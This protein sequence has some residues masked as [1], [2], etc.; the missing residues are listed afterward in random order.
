M[1]ERLILWLI[2]A[3]LLVVGLGFLVAF[4]DSGL[5][6]LGWMVGTAV[7]MIGSFMAFALSFAAN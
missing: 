7:C 6:I 2:S 5:L 1:D 3:A 4:F